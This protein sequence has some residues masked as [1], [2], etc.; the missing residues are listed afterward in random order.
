MYTIRHYKKED[1]KEIASWW[2]HHN[3]EVSPD[4]LSE[5]TTFVLE[6][7]ETPA[8]S[9]TLYLTNCLGVCFLENFIG[10]PL[11]KNKERKEA[12]KSLIEFVYNFAKATGFKNI[13]GFST[14]EKLEDYY[15]ELGMKPLAKNITSMVRSL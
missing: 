4:F 3:K 13:M 10:N 5:E 9:I 12:S 2:A 8:L 7:D 15:Q 1:Y 6:I 14:A 11:L